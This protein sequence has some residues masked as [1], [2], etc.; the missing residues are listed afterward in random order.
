MAVQI[1]RDFLNN[2]KKYM[3]LTYLATAMLQRFDVLRDNY[4]SRNVCLFIPV[5]L[6][7]VPRKRK[8]KK[9]E[10]CT[11][12]RVFSPFSSFCSIHIFFNG[13]FLLLFLVNSA[14][15][16]PSSTRRQL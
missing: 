5:T 11:H 14:H 13:V 6:T 7:F 2:N 1:L 16:N 15:L 10:E 9:V 8:H 12:L 4:V 3:C